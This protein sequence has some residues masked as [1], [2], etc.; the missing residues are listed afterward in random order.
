MIHIADRQV[1]LGHIRFKKILTNN[2]HQSL[3]DNL[4]TFNFKT[5]ADQPFSQYL[6]KRNRV[7]IP[8]ENGE[9]RE[10]I[11]SEAAVNRI[12][13]KVE[14]YSQASFIGLKK[15]KVI[16]PHT[17]DA[18]SAEGHASVALANTEWEPGNIIF[19]GV[20]TLKFDNHSNPYAYLKKVASELNLELDFR[21]EHSNGIITGRYVDM[22]E[23]I[24]TWRGRTAELGRDLLEL[25]RKEKTGNIVTALR[26]VGPER[27]DGTRLEVLVE[28]QDA[29]KRWG[30]QLK[31]G[32]LQHLIEPYEPFSVDY[33][34][35]KSRLRTLT[36]NELEKRINAGVEY[37]G[38]IADLEHIEG[39]ENKKIRFGDTI[40]IKDTSYE[41]SLYLEARIHTQDRNIV[42]KSKK[43]VTLGDYIE[44]TQEQVDAV[45]KSLQAEITKKVSMTEV[46]EVTYDKQTIDSK[47]VPGNEAKTKLDTDVGT[48]TIESITGAQSKAN[49]AQTAAESHADTVANQAQSA[50]E[51]Y[52]VDYAV[53]QTAY[54]NKMQEIANDLADKANLTYVDGQLAMKQEEIP[55]QTTAPAAPTTGMLW[56]DTSQNPNVLKRWDGTAWQKSSPTVAGEIGTYTFT[57]VDKALS[58]KVDTTTYSVDQQG[59]VDR[60]E[61]NETSISQNATA[62]SSKVEQT[63]YEQGIADAKVYADVKSLDQIVRNGFE[64]A[65]QGAWQS[66]V[67]F[68][69]G[70][71]TTPETGLFQSTNTGPPPSGTTGETAL[72]IDSAKA[73]L[74]SGKTIKVSII[75]KQPASNPTAEFAAAYSTNSVGNS[76][77]NYFTPTTSW[78]TYTFYYDVPQNNGNSN[79]HFLGIWGDTT[80]SGLGVLIDSVLIETVDRKLAQD[81]TD[82]AVSPIDSRLTTAESEITQNA[83]AI[84]SKVETAT[85][86]TLEGRVD[87]AE[88]NITQNANAITSKVETS[89]FN[90]L[91][92]RVGSAESTITQ[93][94]NEI[95]TK[96]E[97]NGVI[98]AINQSAE[99]IKI[100]AANIEFQGAVTVLSDITGELGNI[101][102]GNISGVDISGSTFTATGTDGRVVIS[103]DGW[104]VR[105]ANGYVRIGITTTGQTWGPPDP[106]SI[107]FLN[108]WATLRT[109]VGLDVNQDFR[110]NSNFGGIFTAQDFVKISSA[111][112]TEVYGSTARLEATSGNVNIEASNAVAIQAT[113]GN[114]YLNTPNEVRVLAPDQTYG[115]YKPIRASDF[116]VSSIE[117]AKTNIQPWEGNAL[118]ILMNH[119][120]IMKYNLVS[121]W[122]NGINAAKYGFVIGQGYKTPSEI[123]SDDGAAISSY[124]HRS[125]NTKAIQQL[126]GI[127]Y[128]H[129]ERINY[130]EMENETLKA[131][132]KQLEEAA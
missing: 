15:A 20:R 45:W 64:A 3:K 86:N 84:E 7:I 11:I 108:Q 55:Q 37:K 12:T 39:M 83:N 81:Y 38:G 35:T 23:R 113:G 63:T 47:D 107:A 132:I 60:F 120:Q 13:R 22:V 42:D 129:D 51:Q 109:T 69:T 57:E 123:L 104:F 5:Y 4:E 25:S 16:D 92:G 9:M 80:G 76:G 1:L 33:D 70:G 78:T 105:D 53:A 41:P 126:A 94:S 27:E 102:A 114:F 65:I 59:I 88:S 19:N 79:D 32:A 6:V 97:E 127:Y 85:F 124:S 24:G 118:D 77:W 26:G 68:G 99:T 58:A 96:V 131:R 125:L 116:I 72:I 87:T 98:S 128:D 17:T 40:R 56:W 30:T 14:V 50:A 112:S 31:D 91:E 43:K 82:S 49:A 93:H 10:F 90:T 28:N 89:T 106:S 21:I 110:I 95:S 54:D 115:T 8:G 111:G 66:G 117:D 52:T 48:D 36:E 74:L 67:T 73:L 61:S 62:I 34:M 2:H 100:Q 103:D 130:L 29:L 119:A 18:L 122:N 101:T 46:R 75:A 44:Y 121:D 71:I